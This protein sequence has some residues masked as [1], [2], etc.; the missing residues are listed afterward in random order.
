[1]IGIMVVS[2]EPLGTA[3]I[4]CTRHVFGRLPPQLAALDVI[5]DEDPEAAIG[6]ARELLARINDGSGVIV[7]T[8]CFGATPSR[9]AMELAEPLRVYVVAGV[10]LPMLLKA[11]TQRRRPVEEVVDELVA[12]GQGAIRPMRPE[13]REAAR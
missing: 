11:I 8:D 7:F 9:I 13:D 3:L 1:M 10:N 4:R 2:H 5:P 6:A 12:A